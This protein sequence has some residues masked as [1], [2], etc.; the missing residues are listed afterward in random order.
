MGYILLFK[1]IMFMNYD[2]TYAAEILLTASV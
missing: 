1:K 2:L